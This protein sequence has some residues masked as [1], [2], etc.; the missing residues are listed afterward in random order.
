MKLTTICFFCDEIMQFHRQLYIRNLL[1][2][3]AK[4]YVKYGDA[5]SIEQNGVLGFEIQWYWILAL[6][7]YTVWNLNFE[8]M[9]IH[10]TPE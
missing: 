10:L 5:Q 3:S 2:H 4:T 6:E 9:Y 1:V 8:Y 7:N